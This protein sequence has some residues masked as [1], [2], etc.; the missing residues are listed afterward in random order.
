MKEKEFAKGPWKQGNVELEA[1]ILIAVPEPFGGVVIVGQDSICYHNG[2]KYHAVAPPLLRL[3]TITCYCKIDPNG[4]RFLLGDMSGRLFLLLL[5]ADDHVNG[6][7]TVKDIKLELLGEVAI[8]ETMTY[9][10]NGVV[11]VG[12]RLGNSQL[13]RLQTEQNEDGSFLEVMECFP[14]LGPIVDMCVVDIERQGQG[15]LITCSGAFKEGSLRIIRNG[16]GIQEHATIELSGIKGIWPLQISSSDRFNNVLVVSFVGETRVLSIAGE[17][18]S[19]IEI[20]GFDDQSQTFIAGNVSHKQILQVT[21]NSARLVSAADGSLLCE[22]SPPDGQ[23]ISVVSANNHQIVCA[24]RNRIFFMEIGEKEIRLVTTAEMEFEIACI[25]I[26]PLSPDEEKASFCSV[27]LWSD[28]SIRVLKLPDLMEMHKERLDGEIIPRSII[29]TTF[30]NSH[31]LLCA[32]GDGSLFYFSL[33]HESGALS[34]R[35]KVTLGTQPTVL[36][37]FKSHDDSTNV[38]ACSDRPTVIYSSSHKL[39]FSNVN[40]KEVNHMCPLNAESYPESLALATDSLLLIGTIDEIQKLHI[41]TILLG[42]S[43]RRIAYQESTKTFGL[44]TQRHDLQDGETLQPARDSASTTA[45]STSTVSASG[46]ISRP[47][48]NT[49]GD[50]GQEVDVYNLLILD[51]HTFEVCHALQFLPGE[52]AMSVISTKLGTDDTFFVVGTCFINP[53]EPEPKLGRLIVFQWTDQQKLLPVAEKEIKGAPY[54]LAEFNGKLLASINSTVR[55]FEFTKERE[56]HNECSFYNN[57]MALF[58]KTKGDFILVGD[59]MRSIALLNYK[60]MEMNLEEISR[61]FQPNWLSAIEILDDDNFLGAESSF[62]LF[63]CQKDSAAA[64]DEERLHL[65]EAGLF[66]LGE[67]VNVFRHGSLVMQN[68]GEKNT[69]VQGSVLFGTVSGS[70]G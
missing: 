70:I 60:P 6:G 53:E 20:E 34:E 51:Q 12:S 43:P 39:V 54:T 5:E 69:P 11:Y 9:L 38:F 64:T 37:S 10:D 32:L 52:A 68:L 1:S 62:N 22:W 61:D 48:N 31:Y 18:V 46:S 30:E 4:S 15:Q 28:I 40:M 14:N 45:V 47:T 27:G 59:L 17:E 58:M 33:N 67:Y 56:L 21:G 41:R 23:K 49:S 36:R 29:M 3:S 8:P 66:H 25:D 44:I 19:A 2:D 7:N 13:V 50:C 65:Q 35:K 24:G 57:I 55:L 63:V 26:S 42:E 16:I